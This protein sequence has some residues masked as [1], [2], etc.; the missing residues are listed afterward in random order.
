MYVH[1]RTLGWLVRRAF[2]RKPFSVRRCL[3]AAGFGFGQAMLGAV[4]TLARALDRLQY[5]EFTA[6]PVPAP[7][8]VIATPRSGTT[9]LHHLLELDEER[10][11]SCKLYQTI[12]PSIALDRGLRRAGELDA[13]TGRVFGRLIDAI[14]SRMF[15]DWEAIHR[16]SLR[17]A[18]E[19]ENLFVS[20]LTSPALYLL[21]PFIR[22]LPEFVEI[23]RLGRRAVRRV[24]DDY[25]ETLRRWVYLEGDARTPL[26]KNVLL[27]SRLA[28]SDRAFPAARYVHVVRDPREAIPS[29]VSMF[30]AM[31]QSHSPNIAARSPATRAL[32]DMF[33]HHYRLLCD[34]GR[35][36]PSDRWVQVRYEALVEDPV[37]TVERIYAAFGFPVS[38]AFRAR[39]A[40]AAGEARRF[41]SR[42]RYDPSEFGLTEDD[43]RAGLGEHW[44]SAI[45]ERIQRTSV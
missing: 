20:S 16:V 34:E 11:F 22:E 18:E 29:A 32:A 44:Q 15:T 8:F 27:P 6:L 25:R 19:D 28:V 1:T 10:F 30:Y 9:Y 24:A 40:H 36:R 31:W 3:Y 21:F 37:G 35:K 14:D 5:P 2:F 43:L 33:L 13:A 39:L 7:L 12:L 38:A 4:V 45:G 23:S 26:I 41:K 42:H 17:S